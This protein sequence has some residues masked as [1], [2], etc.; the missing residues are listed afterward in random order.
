[1]VDFLIKFEHQRRLDTDYEASDKAFR[2]NL[3]FPV[4][5]AFVAS[6]AGEE[7]PEKVRSAYHTRTGIVL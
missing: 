1:M 7:G 3:Y 6:L 5:S 2:F 4:S